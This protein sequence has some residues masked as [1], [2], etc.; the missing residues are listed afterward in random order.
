MGRFETWMATNARPPVRGRPLPL[1]RC[2]PRGNEGPQQGQ[3]NTSQLQ[4]RVVCQNSQDLFS[5]I[6]FSKAIFNYV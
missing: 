5:T 1:Y 4:I 6:D 3:A 2:A